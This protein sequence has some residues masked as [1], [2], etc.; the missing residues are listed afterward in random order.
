MGA[1]FFSGLGDVIDTRILENTKWTRANYTDN[2]NK[3]TKMGA[4]ITKNFNTETEDLTDILNKA[5]AL[6]IPKSALQGAYKDG[7]MPGLKTFVDTVA[8]RDDLTPKDF[9]EL[10]KAASAYADGADVDF[11]DALKRA[12]N[13]IPRG[14][15]AK[16]NKASWIAHMIGLGRV[17]EQ[18][19]T[20]TGPLG[21]LSQSQTQAA[22]SS[23]GSP[24]SG[25]TTLD[26][27]KFPDVRLDP[28]VLNAF[29]ERKED[30]AEADQENLITRLENVA[31][32]ENDL[33]RLGFNQKLQQL[34]NLNISSGTGIEQ[35]ANVIESINNAILEQMKTVPELRNPDG[36]MPTFTTHGRGIMSA[37]DLFATAYNSDP[38][39]I[40]DNVNYS[41]SF[42]EN[43]KRYLDSL[44]KFNSRKEAT[45]KISKSGNNYYIGMYPLQRTDANNI[46]TDNFVFIG[47]ELVMG[48]A[49]VRGF[50]G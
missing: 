37:Y 44:P 8:K 5:S 15:S 32:P 4:A 43:Y 21:E 33:E 2:K 47:D 13:V 28:T 26:D 17:G 9:Q 36:S 16:N 46:I 29:N 45:D 11:N 41:T 23:I 20:A 18:P 50:D 1:G 3:A 7:K 14:G 38:R 31:L 49:L 42:K 27:I 35:F 24:Y 22:F 48:S 10:Y 34:K 39:L 6:N 40:F 30:S 25:D 12:L 19:I